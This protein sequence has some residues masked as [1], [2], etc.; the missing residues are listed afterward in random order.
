MCFSMQWGVAYINFATLMKIKDWSLAN[1]SLYTYTFVSDVCKKLS[2]QTCYG[3][4][5]GAIS[6]LVSCYTNTDEE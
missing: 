3:M 2:K 6:D 4:Q 1:S 5:W